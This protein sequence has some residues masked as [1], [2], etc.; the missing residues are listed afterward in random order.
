MVDDVS[1]DVA[2]TTHVDTALCWKTRASIV[3]KKRA[4][5]KSYKEFIEKSCVGSRK[6][7]PMAVAGIQHRP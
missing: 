3:V 4:V 5:M 6:L 1:F 2:E 7:L